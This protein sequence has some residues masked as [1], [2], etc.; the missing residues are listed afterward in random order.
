MSDCRGT[1]YDSIKWREETMKRK[2][3]FSK[4]K[5][6]NTQFIGLVLLIGI[7]SFLEEMSGLF[8]LVT[9][10]ICF[11]LSLSLQDN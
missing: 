1:R 5:M 4:R 11:I 9:L 7:F 10:L 8:F 6:D 2:K 3:P